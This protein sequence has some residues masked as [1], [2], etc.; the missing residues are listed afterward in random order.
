ML[1]AWA[2]LQGAWGLKLAAWGLR[3]YRA[4]SL[5]LYA[6]CLKLG[7]RRTRFDC[8]YP[9]IIANGLSPILHTQFF[10]KFWW[11]EYMCHQC[12]PYDTFFIS[13]FQQFLQSLHSLFC[14]GAGHVAPAVTT[15]DVL[16]QLPPAAWSIIGMLN[17][18]TKLSGHNFKK[19]LTH[20]SRVGSQC[21]TEGLSLATAK[22]FI[23][24]NSSWTSPESCHL[25]T[26][27]FLLLI[28]SCIAPD[29][30]GC[31]MLAS[32]LYCAAWTTGKT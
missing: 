23:K 14:F 21:L 4:W 32:L 28:R 18:I 24:C 10:I 19:R 25:K 16:C 13:G 6:W 17:R 5:R 15:V 30:S 29:Q 26:F 3:L 7:P 22:I 1:A 31:V 9:R 8:G 12:F 20:A 27:D 2:L 11:F